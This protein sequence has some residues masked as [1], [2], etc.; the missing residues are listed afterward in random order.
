MTENLQDRIKAAEKMGKTALSSKIS[1]AKDVIRLTLGGSDIS[2][3]LLKAAGEDGKSVN[4]YTKALFAA[5]DS[6]S[7]FFSLLATMRSSWMP[8]DDEG[9]STFGSVRLIADRQGALESYENTFLRMIGMPSSA[10]ISS[11]RSCL[12]NLDSNGN[13]DLA[14]TNLEEGIPRASINGGLAGVLNQRQNAE[15]KRV[16]ESKMFDMVKSGS[17]KDVNPVIDDDSLKLISEAVDNIKKATKGVAT[18][19]E[20]VVKKYNTNLPIG[21]DIIQAFIAF[22]GFLDSQD[23]GSN[24]YLLIINSL[25]EDKGRA[26][27]LF[28]ELY[29]APLKDPS[30][31]MNLENKEGFY[32]YCHLLFPPIHDGEIAR[33]INEAEKIVAEPFLPES[34]RVVNRKKIKPTL[35]EAVIRIRL[36]NASGSFPTPP[37]PGFENSSEPPK[38]TESLGPLEAMIISR[39]YDSIPALAKHVDS[40]RE[41]IRRIQRRTGM[42]PDDSAKR[43]SDGAKTKQIKAKNDSIPEEYYRSA[44]MVEDS[45]MLFLGRGSDSELINL[46][47]NTFRRSSINSAHLMGPVTSIIGA[48]GSALD[49]EMK[50]G[51]EKVKRAADKGADKA[52]TEV[53]SILGAHKGVGI[54][55]AVAFS[56][57]LF[58]APEGAL[59]GLLNDE[60]YK[61]M[62]SEFP[63]GHF[64]LINRM[65]MVNSVNII[66]LIVNSVY[67]IFRSNLSVEAQ[68]AAFARDN[69]KGPAS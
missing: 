39:L 7:S 34:Q 56:L 21:A 26:E 30:N 17:A 27:K 54:I 10:D 43:T 44:K 18:S 14:S 16:H 64:S 32:K 19:A 13:L 12:Y 38:L 63:I 37:L 25:K 50:K 66:T 15:E 4:E 41:E 1:T 20:I 42:K 5:F 23:S 24:D 45:M 9:N 62:T 48:V 67:D 29:G 57:A 49:A 8:I 31:V 52:M 2:E 60:Q 40:K 47:E 35:L 65:D 68:G 46:Q 28:R 3:D 53:S 36:D 11:C 59:L 33:C 22:K 55:D 6:F 58:S 61:N 69:P 51:E